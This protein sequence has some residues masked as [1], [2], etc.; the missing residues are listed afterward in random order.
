MN[1]RDAV[2]SAFQQEQ[3]ALN[4]LDAAKHA[5]EIAV[6]S[7]KGTAMDYLDQQEAAT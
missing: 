7:G 1:V 6:E 5:V 3:R 4:L 2:L